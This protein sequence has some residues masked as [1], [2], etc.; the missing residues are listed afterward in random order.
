MVD[1]TCAVDGCEARPTGGRGWCQRHYM[2]WYHHGDPLRA[3]PIGSPEERFESKVER[4][5]PVPEARPDLGPC[6]IW[7]EIVSTN[8]GY[9][10]FWDGE[11]TVT[12]HRWSY[13]RFVGPI[14]DGLQLDHLC[15]VRACCNPTH[16]EPVTQLVNIRRSPRIK[17][18][19]CPQGHEYTPETSRTKKTGSRS[20]V[21]CSNARRRARRAAQ[22]A[23]RRYEPEGE[24]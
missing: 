10:R 9:G 11:R 17:P 15:R 2:S 1:G 19:H 14:P 21:I 8:G 7:P 22:R 18:T 23:E 24:A 5:G 6:W 12:T 20:C 4:N 13:E 16:L 3:R